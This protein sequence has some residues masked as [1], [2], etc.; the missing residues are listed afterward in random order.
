MKIRHRVWVHE[1]GVGEVCYFSRT[2]AQ[3]RAVRAETPSFL[4]RRFEK[5]W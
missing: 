2:C 3:I 5:I 4:E 1:P